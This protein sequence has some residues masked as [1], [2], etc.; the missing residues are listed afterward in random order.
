MSVF[1]DLKLRYSAVRMAVIYLSLFCDM[2]KKSL[3]IFLQET[4]LLGLQQSLKFFFCVLIYIS[5]SLT[6]EAYK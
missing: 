3:T 4:I 6:M 5:L 1:G 2:M